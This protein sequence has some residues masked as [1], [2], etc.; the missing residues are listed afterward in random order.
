MGKEL[1]EDQLPFNS[2]Q[3]FLFA[4]IFKTGCYDQ[5]VILWFGFGKIQN[6][7]TGILGQFG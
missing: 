1:Q 2:L 7:L 5:D 6:L 3:Y 4:P